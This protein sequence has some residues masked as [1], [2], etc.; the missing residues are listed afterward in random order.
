[1]NKHPFKTFAKFL[2]L[3]L[4]A[5][6]LP[7][8]T[9]SEGGMSAIDVLMIVFF[10]A[11]VVGLA[12]MFVME[13]RWWKPILIALILSVFVIQVW[14]PGRYGPSQTLRPGLDL[15]GGTTLVYEMSMSEDADAEQVLDDTI[16]VLKQRIDPNN[17]MNLVFRPQ[18]PNR[19]EIEM[20]LA[21]PETKKRRE[22]YIEAREKVVEANI[23]E[24]DLDAA[25]RASG[26]DLDA[27]LKRLSGGNAKMLERLNAASDAYG[28]REE[29]RA[30]N[31]EL[32]KQA[33]E[34]ASKIKALG[35]AED[36]AEEKKKLEEELKKVRADQVDVARK[37]IAANTA[38]ADAR[39]KVLQHNLSLGQLTTALNLTDEK[40]DDQ[41]ESK[42][43]AAL[44][45][46]MADYPGRKTLI[47]DAFGKHASYQKVRGP[48]D[49]YT[50]LIRLLQ[51]SG[52]LE[53]RIAPAPGALGDEQ[54]YVTD[55]NEKGPKT[56]GK[57]YRW[58][59]IDKL[60]NFADTPKQEREL[61]EDPRGFL[62]GRGLIAAPYGE[63]IYVLLSDEQSSSL[64]QKQDG[65]ELTR[66]ASTRDNDGLP[67]VSFELNALGGDYMG[68]LTGAHTQQPMAILLDGKLMSAP[69]IQSRISSRGI[70]TG[71]RGGFDQDEMTYLIRTLN[72]GSLQANL[73][74]Y[75]VS[76]QN[77]DAKLGADN[78]KSGFT[79]AIGAMILVAI[80]MAIYY[81]FGGVVANFA[82]FA[83]MALILGVMSMLEA[84]FTLPGIA[85]IV[86]TIG[87]TVDA[88]VLIFERIREELENKAE[89][90][91]AIR[92][93]YEKALATI[94]DANLTT[95]IT[96]L[97]LGYM[98]TAE[99]KGFAIVLGIGIMASMFTALFCTRVI[100][101]LYVDY[102]NPTTM[103]MLPTQIP[104]IR[105]LLHPNIDWVGKRKML[106]TGSAIV[107][108]LSLVAISVRGGDILDIEFRSGTQVTLNLKEGV[109]MDIATFRDRLSKAADAAELPDLHGDTASILTINRDTDGQASEFKI[110][111][112]VE[113]SSKVSDAIRSE[114]KDVLDV[115][116]AIKFKGMGDP[117]Q[118]EGPP[119]NESPVFVIN[120]D[121][122]GQ[123]INRPDIASGEGDT[124]LRE[125]MGGVAVVID[126]MNP[127]STVADVEDR[128]R[129]ARFNPPH[130][131]YGSRSF[132]VIGLDGAGNATEGE[133]LYKSVVVISRDDETNYLD[134]LASF[135]ARNGL[136]ATEWNLVRDALT[137]ESS[138]GSVTNFTPSISGTMQEKAFGALIVSLLAVVVYIWFLFGS[139]R[140][141]VAAIIA[142]VHDVTIALG[143]VAATKLIGMDAIRIDLVMIGA[144][145]TIVGYSLNDT[146]VVFDRIR[147]NRGRMATA[148]GAIINESINQTVSRTVLTSGTTFLAVLTLYLFGGGGVHGFAFSMLI[149]VIV[150][151]YSSIGIASSFLMVGAKNG[152][153]D[154]SGNSG[155]SS[156]AKA[157]APAAA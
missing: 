33:D 17:L 45:Q 68:A 98:G 5:L 119:V 104:K 88:N 118:I 146:I 145:L 141:G 147:E 156:G 89:L 40:D 121:K 52:V 90:R 140:Y 38:L 14:Y 3:A 128:V 113:D 59:P 9:D 72:A 114:F 111:T 70:I 97:V 4:F 69:T 25:L 51:G 124:Q 130:D 44:N 50:D 126:E 2:A 92:V 84:T 122:L 155:S 34:L 135:G 74:D 138:L 73:G 105:D 136:A 76:I 42:R 151:T 55:L 54:Q 15:A 60:K 123:V 80:F 67:A 99:V 133:Q 100:V 8:A 24:R 86:L 87:M 120:S 43:D 46:L 91:T 144:V 6:A 153:S 1:M 154:N 79:A 47:E 26:D 29:T 134:D 30:P 129:R 152:N 21:P 157:A 41:A 94:I 101:D 149:G 85:G 71:G 36:K 78:I 109:K 115:K 108:A 93:G 62:A 28:N 132:A 66:A 96:C 18:P 116:Q 102:C 107:M 106:W 12:A 10:G 13:K 65:W 75:P 39:K 31:D 139:L 142:L 137:R 131:Q 7:G 22:A 63:G 61:R 112:L 127:A 48:L 58:I 19:I 37:F 16:A 23:N 11:L 117:K 64:T 27:Q 35:D 32:Q 95:L 81:M 57:P 110:A 49:D 20:A 83:N 103:K 143:F 150:G 148:T 77:I 53:F 125:F 56:S 82:L